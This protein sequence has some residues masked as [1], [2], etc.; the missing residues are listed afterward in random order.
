LS[1]GITYS[2]YAIADDGTDTTQ[3]STW[4]FTTYSDSPT[5]D[6]IPTDQIIEFSNGLSYDVNAS[7]SSG[8]DHWWINDTINF[9]IDAN[10][11]IIN[12][13]AF[14]VGVYWLEVRAYDPFGY[15][16]TTTIMINVSDTIAPTWDQ[17][18]IDQIIE[19]GDDLNYDLNASDISGIDHWWINNTINFNIDPNGVISNASALTIGVYFLEVRVYDPYGNYYSSTI[20]I[21]VKDEYKPPIDGGGGGGGGGGG[22]KEE[23]IL[24]YDLF[25]ILGT[26]FAI[27]II[28]I[29]KRLKY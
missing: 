4:S 10:G 22:D 9:N 26:I 14:S 28:M 16:C 1:E 8:I 7:D 6:E 24:G 2:W 13:V 17:I 11:L 18:P 29:Y 21:T 25:V 3:S 20:K 15:Y 12:A 23:E 19:F 5:W 27:S